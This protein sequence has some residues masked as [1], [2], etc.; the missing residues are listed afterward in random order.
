MK[1]VLVALTMGSACGQRKMAGILRYLADSGAHWN[2]VFQREINRLSEEYIRSLPD[3]GIDGII[4][5]CPDLLE[6]TAALAGQDIP[7]VAVDIFDRSVLDRRSRNVAFIQSDGLV[8]GRAAADFL[9]QQGRYRSFAYVSDPNGHAWSRERQEG[10]EQALRRDGIRCVCYRRR[11][12]GLDSEALGE[13]LV[14]LPKPAAVFVAYDD[15]ALCVLEACAERSLSVP[16]DVGIV[17]VDNDEII[18]AHTTP[19]LTSIQADHFRIGYRAAELLEDMMDGK[20]LSRPKIER[21]GIL[22]LAERE[23]SSPTSRG[24]RLVQRALAFISENACRGICVDDVAAAVKCS[25]RLLD[26]RFSEMASTSIA[27]TIRKTRLEEIRRRLAEPKA[28]RDKVAAECGFASV[29]AMSE[30]LRRN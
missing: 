12:R 8:I 20:I 2:L 1:R 3:R 16:D 28:S 23:S 5:S 17:S 13:F 21:V 9:V 11:G 26:L 4:Y 25:R 22:R 18:C 6:S 29:R 27:A 30:F 19:T 14:K 7:L 10:F 15:R 24:G